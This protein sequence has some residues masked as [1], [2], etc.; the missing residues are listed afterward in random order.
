MKNVGAYEP[1]VLVMEK[2]VIVDCSI[3]LFEIA[4]CFEIVPAN[5]VDGSSEEGKQQI[6][7]ID[8]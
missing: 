7:Q 1:D 3:E 4:V 8:E 5:C 2:Q 6:Y